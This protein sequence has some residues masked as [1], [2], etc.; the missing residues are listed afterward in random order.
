MTEFH[1]TYDA[2]FDDLEGQGAMNVDVG[3]LTA[4]VVA[5]KASVAKQSPHP[6]CVSGVCD[7]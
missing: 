6:R 2:L 4:A 1:R 7:E 3:R 5:A